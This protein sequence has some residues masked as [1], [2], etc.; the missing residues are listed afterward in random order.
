LLKT[1]IDLLAHLREHRK[2]QVRS[3]PAAPAGG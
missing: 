3:G 1:A 2:A